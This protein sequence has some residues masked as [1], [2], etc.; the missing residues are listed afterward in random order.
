MNSDLKI[1]REYAE[2]VPALSV[3]EY[4]AL[5]LSISE[6][7]FWK[8]NP[9]V[10][11]NEGIILDG[12]HRYKACKELQVEPI[13][14]TAELFDDRLEEKLYVINSNLTRRQLNSFQRIELALKEKP[15]L[16]EIAKRN[17]EPN[18]KQNNNNKN[19]NHKPSVRIQTVGIGRVDQE[20]GRHA[21]VGK[22]T[23]RKV[24]MILQKAPQDLLDRA[25]KGQWAI[26]RL[27]KKLEYEQK[28]KDLINTK[29]VISGLS[30]ALIIT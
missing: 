22:D 10:V 20:I 6:K 17:S 14:T 23:V 30:A 28:R 26:H 16:E 2:L 19:N 29:S 15:I 1:N 12:H 8:S 25:R 4:E 7:G 27:Y 18:L 9:I 3:Q 13:T 24:E 21:G 11:N 5:K